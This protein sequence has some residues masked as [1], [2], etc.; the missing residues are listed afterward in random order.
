MASVRA[1]RAARAAEPPRRGRRP[2]APPPSFDGMPRLARIKLSGGL[3]SDDV[4]VNSKSLALGLTG[5]V[6]FIGIAVA[7][8]TWLGSSLFDARE[9]FARSA[10]AVAANVGFE[11]AEVEVDRM[12]HALPISDARKQEV[13]TLI[14]GGD[15]RSILA[16]DPQEVRAR[17]ENL[18]WVAQAR[19]RRLWPSTLRI[20]V[21]RRQEYAVWENEGRRSV[22]DVN[23]EALAAADAN[24][25]PDLV[26]VVGAGAGPA[27]PPLLDALEGL[28]EVRERTAQLVRVNDRR[29]SLELVSGL[30]IALPDE[31]AA[32]ALVRLEH[33]QKRYAL[34]DRPIAALDMRAP[35]RLAVRIH[36]ELAGG[37]RALLGGV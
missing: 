12:P 37:P 7:G 8:A 9:A 32:E 1:R 34:L 5:V 10:D 31:G 15:S 28:P 11:I 25:F 13:R 29:W 2:A 30:E 3:S 4:P 35:G 19:V 24:D 26:R 16:A 22:I 14:R 18:D 6:I 21:E 23:G 36:P 17:I 27:A 20:E 33:L